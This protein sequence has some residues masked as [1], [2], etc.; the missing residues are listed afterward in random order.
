MSFYSLSKH[1]RRCK[2]PISS[3]VHVRVYY[4]TGPAISEATE[5]RSD[6]IGPD[7]GSDAMEG[8]EGVDEVGVGDEDC[9]GGRKDTIPGVLLYV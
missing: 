1:E 3:L 7:T 2:R 4:E 5:T 6:R 8:K 9:N